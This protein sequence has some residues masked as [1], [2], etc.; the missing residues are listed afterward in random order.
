LDKG[1][2]HI[3]AVNNEG[4]TPLHCVVTDGST[5]QQRPGRF[6]DFVASRN[7]MF[8]LLLTKGANPF[9]KNREGLNAMEEYFAIENH[10]SNMP[11]KWSEFCVRDTLDWMDVQE[12]GTADLKEGLAKEPNFPD[13]LLEDGKVTIPVTD[14]LADCFS[15]SLQNKEQ[16]IQEQLQ[17]QMIA[18]QRQF[19]SL[20]GVILSVLLMLVAAMYV[21]HNNKKKSIT[22][23]SSLNN[24]QHLYQQQ[25]QQGLSLLMGSKSSSNNDCRDDTTEESSSSCSSSDFCW[26]SPPPPPASSPYATS[27]IRRQVVQQGT[28][29]WPSSSSSPA[30]PTIILLAEGYE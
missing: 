14:K 29:M 22:H 5:L 10:H 9:W 16:L 18:E 7:E 15:P 8:Q 2:A 4:S 28:L 11:P 23:S 13:Y 24:K 26:L 1:H 30:T 21:K 17:Q 6:D 27:R 25:Q 19:F 12:D 20:S 3:N